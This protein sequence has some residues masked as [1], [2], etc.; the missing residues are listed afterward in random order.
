MD[1]PDTWY[2]VLPRRNERRDIF[3]DQEDYRKLL[4]SNHYHFVV[5][6]KEPGLSRAI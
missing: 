5:L 3:Y 2:H 6:T 1:Y 4:M